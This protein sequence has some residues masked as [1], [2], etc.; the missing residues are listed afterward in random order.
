MQDGLPILSEIDMNP[1]SIYVVVNFALFMIFLLCTTFYCQIISLDDLKDLIL[2]SSLW[3]NLNV[4]SY[5]YAG[6]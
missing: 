6:T 3:L 1:G 4:F 5:S 2:V